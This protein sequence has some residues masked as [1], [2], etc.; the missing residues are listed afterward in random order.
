MD[1]TE[2]ENLVASLNGLLNETNLLVVTQQSGLTVAESSDLRNQMR[3]EGASF[4]VVKNRLARFALEGTK[5]AEL[6]PLFKGPTAIATSGDPVAAAKVAVRFAKDNDKLVIVGGALDGQTLDVDGI[7]A[8]AALPSLDELRAK[9]V[10]MVSTP[11]TRIARVLS[12]PGGQVARV[13]AAY[14][15]KGEA[16]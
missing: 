3:E 1:R 6:T 10:G 14:S 2:K 5:F 11:A 4:K 7:K 13:I 8:L 16:A 9:I 15:E 12:A